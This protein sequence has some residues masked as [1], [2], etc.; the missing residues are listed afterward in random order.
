MSPVPR[1][2]EHTEGEP[3]EA[4]AV[5]AARL[6]IAGLRLRRHLRPRLGG[7]NEHDG[8]FVVRGIVGSVDLGAGLVL[9][10]VPKTEHGEDW[11]HAVLDLLVGS[12][13][14]DA[15]GERAAGLSPNRRSLLDVLA[16]HYA[17]R[18]ERALRRDGP[19]LLLE[20][21]YTTVP[22]LKGKLDV[23]QWVRRATSSPN[24]FPVSFDLLTPDHDISRALAL[25]ARMLAGAARSPETRGRLL[26]AVRGLRPG[27]AEQVAVSQAVVTRRLPPQW[28]IYEPAWSIARAVLMQRSL[29]GATGSHQGISVAIEAWPLLERLLDRTLASAVRQAYATGEELA[30]PPRLRTILLDEPE[31]SALEAQYVEPDGRLERDGATI[32]IFDAKYKRRT[33][34]R[35]WPSRTDI[36]QAVVTAAAC[37]SPLAVLVYPEDFPA[38][39]WRVRGAGGHPVRLAAIGLGLF[40]Y[41]AGAGDEARGSRV[42]EIIYAPLVKQDLSETIDIVPK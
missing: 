38:A 41:R 21:Q 7:I 15:A 27:A 10:V 4:D 26:T 23:S 18:L 11:I 28:A 3:F 36:H 17:A 35:E 29:F 14:I 13:R 37:G 32:A 34:A 25:V 39:W 40:G 24:R 12:D 6:R 30:A 9:N 22:Y 20:Q 1:T 5:L 31:G 8:R 2:I 16:S 33:G 42:L 19:I